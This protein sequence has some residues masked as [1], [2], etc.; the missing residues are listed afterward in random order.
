MYY[1]HGNIF[2]SNDF[3]GIVQRSLIHLS[4]EGD[5]NLFLPCAHTV[6]ISDKTRLRYVHDGDEG[7]LKITHGFSCVFKVIIRSRFDFYV[8]K[9]Q[10]GN[11]IHSIF[12]NS[13]FGGA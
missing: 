7:I 2:N 9:Y 1:R 6:F 3:M 13:N 12:E 8:T 11:W 5:R 4:K 10:S